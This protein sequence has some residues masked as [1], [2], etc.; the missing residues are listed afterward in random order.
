MMNGKSNGVYVAS[1][2]AAEQARSRGAAFLDSTQMSAFPELLPAAAAEADVAFPSGPSGVVSPVWESNSGLLA[3]SLLGGSLAG[4][5]A[6]SP[7]LYEERFADP[8]WNHGLTYSIYPT[9]Y[10]AA[11]GLFATAAPAGSAEDAVEDYNGDAVDVPRIDSSAHI[12]NLIAQYSRADVVAAADAA[13]ATAAAT[14]VFPSDDASASRGFSFS[15]RQPRFDGPSGSAGAGGAVWL[16]NSAARS[17]KFLLST[18]YDRFNRLPGV[19]EEVDEPR[20]LK[21]QESDTWEVLRAGKR[22]RTGK[23]AQRADSRADDASRAEVE[24][25]GVKE[26]KRDAERIVAEEKDQEPAGATKG[27]GADAETSLVSGSLAAGLLAGWAHAT[28]VAE[29]P[30]AADAV[31][32]VPAVALDGSA[33]PYHTPHITPYHTPERHVGADLAGLQA[34]QGVPDACAAG[35]ELPA[36]V[37]HPGTG[38][39]ELGLLEDTWQVS[40]ST[41]RAMREWLETV[42]GTREAGE[43][44]GEGEGVGDEGEGEDGTDPFDWLLKASPPHAHEGDLPSEGVL[45]RDGVSTQWGVLPNWVLEELEG[46]GEEEGMEKKDELEDYTEE[47]F[48]EDEGLQVLVRA[49]SHESSTA[50]PSVYSPWSR[51]VESGV[52]AAEE[53]ETQ[54]VKKQQEEDEGKGKQGV[55]QQDVPSAWMNGC[56]SID[57]GLDFDESS[58]GREIEAQLLA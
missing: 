25:P 12:N 56:D 27:G 24:T 10:V 19:A 35:T 39:A 20:D 44:D 36:D 13:E 5:L 11:S 40:Y 26:T 21:L 57:L 28:A 2:G 46:G 54:V 30:A 29:L 55:Q 52:R 4:A 50:A 14:L 42:G 43:G 41:K 58:F 31:A 7:V 53:G 33:T 22:L 47:A 48:S 49:D 17:D 3:G 34:A 9:D 8:L 45:P 37:A 6:D 18:P 38:V 15:F 32:E 23:E 16:E 1:A 51:V